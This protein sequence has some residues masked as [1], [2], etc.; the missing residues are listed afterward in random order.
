MVRKTAIIFISIF[1]FNFFPQEIFS[2]IIFRNI[3][4]YDISSSK[5]DF[6]QY[7]SSRKRIILNGYWEV[8]KADDSDLKK[9]T[10]I[11][12]SVFDGNEDLIFEKEFE[13]N[14]NEIKNNNFIIHFLGINNYAELSLNNNVI[15]KNYDSN[16][17]FSFVL[18]KDLL[19]SNQKNNLT[20]KVSN[21][22]D[23]KNTIP[24]KPGFL[25]P[26]SLGGIFRDVFIEIVPNVFISNLNFNYEVKNNNY[27]EL[28]ISSIIVNDDFKIKSD[29]LNNNYEIRITINNAN[30]LQES[31]IAQ[32]SSTIKLPVGKN[33]TI[34]Q[35]LVIS[36]FNFWSPENPIYYNLT[37]QVYKDGNLIDELTKQISFY[38][39]NVQEDN[40]LLN[41]SP[42]QLKGVTYISSNYNYGDMISYSKMESDIQMIK[43]LG[44]NAIRFSK[45]VPHPYLISLCEK[46]GLLAFVEL[47]L[48]SLPESILESRIFLER[49][50]NYLRRFFNSYNSFSSIAGI[51]LGSSYLGNS[52]Q[53][54]FFLSQLSSLTKQLTNKITYASFIDFNIDKIDN[55][56][57]YGI[58]LLNPKQENFNK[59]LNSI[60]ELMDK[61]GKGRVFISEAGYIANLGSSTGSTNPHTF[62]AQAKFFEDLLNYSEN[63]PVSG[64]FINT[65][66][67]YRSDYPS[68]ISGYN[69]ENKI[70][71]G[72][73]GEDHSTNRLGYKVIYSKLHNLE[74]VTI[75][76]GIK[77]DDSP[78][79]F[80]IFGLLLALYTGFLFNTGKKFREDA[81]RALL[82]PYNFYSDIRDLRIISGFQSFNLG[83]VISGVV[84]LLIASLFYYFRFN[85]F[86]EKLL[87]SFGSYNL[88]KVSSYLSWNPTKS[89][90]ILT[91]VTF[92]IFLLITILVKLFSLLNRHKIFLSSSFYTVVWS[93]LPMIVLIPLV[94]LLYRLLNAS[95]ANIYI[96]I[97]LGIYFIWLILRFL[98]AVY[99]VYDIPAG[100]VYF[101][102]F[103]IVLVVLGSFLFYQQLNYLTIDYII[104]SFKVIN[105]L[106]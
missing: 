14:E 27:C 56:D 66:F 82:R 55:I 48:N 100:K 16:F 15:Y 26:K 62:E 59:S 81:M 49:T 46:Y 57:F 65:M 33:E 11:I 19:K 47:P 42:F 83:I 40:L 34:S 77:K 35:K 21:K 50:E 1:I 53:G 74:K 91:I 68:I 17:P 52:Q 22:L 99:V 60:N 43:E 84:A 41:G 24:L 69:N 30:S 2:Q 86:F 93:L 31:A 39:L 6:Y 18:P 104:H 80:I 98:K 8:Y 106:V 71:L 37:I 72:I 25:F 45:T 32:T 29:S 97:F 28:N 64:F 79:I 36:N 9:K 103:I 61:I 51:G 78:M 4:N 44:F 73:V 76:L 23:S 10:I 101:Y 95:V 85:I 7:S 87:L 13:L 90:I 54:I 3:P 58:E 88:I 75:P 20:V 96:Y 5:L 70:Y 102:C 92:I 12:P 89:L 94:I 105:S 67:D 38:S 63:N